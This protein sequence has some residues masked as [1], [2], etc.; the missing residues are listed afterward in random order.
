MAVQPKKN[1]TDSDDFSDSSA[2]P[3]SLSRK[4]DKVS[5]FVI[6][7]NEEGYIRDCL[8]SLAF[9]DE[10]IVIDSFSTDRTAEIAK[11]MGAKVISRK[12]PGYRAQKAFGLSQVTHDWVINIDADER[13]DSTLRQEIIE[14]LSGR[15][16]SKP[17]EPIVGYRL[18]RVV[19]HLGRWWRSGG[20][21]PEYRLRFFR[22]DAVVWGGHDPHEKPISCGR[23]EK[24]KGELS[25]YS[26]SDLDDQFK[27]LVKFASL[28]A[29][30]SF[31]LGKK[32][33]IFDLVVRPFLR[34]SKFF[35][36]KR[37]YREGLAGLVVAL[38]EGMYTFMKYARLWELH[39]NARSE[40]IK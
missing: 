2:D 40:S 6:A 18:N 10:V 3:L 22:K 1:Q 11:G 16:A 36:L 25:H 4:R 27:R 32:V 7:F 17:G 9:C 34:V 24:L 8:A 21:Y 26:Y 29:E 38:A 33:S 19:F 15:D 13:I 14:V 35:I 5:A 31:R 23:L 37:G 20:W 39:Y 30:E 12:W 28:S